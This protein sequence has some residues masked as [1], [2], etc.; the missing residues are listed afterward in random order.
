MR[1][2]HKPQSPMIESFD[3]VRGMLLIRYEDGTSSRLEDPEEILE[4]EK[5]IKAQLKAQTIAFLSGG[6]SWFTP[7]TPSR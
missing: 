4:A 3:F 6:P 5:K 2:Q 1:P 7:E